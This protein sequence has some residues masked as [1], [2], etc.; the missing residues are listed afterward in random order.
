MTIFDLFDVF[1]LK[2]ITLSP[3]RCL[4]TLASTEAPSIAGAPKVKFPLSSKS[5]TLSKET[6]APSLMI[7]DE[8][9]LFGLLQF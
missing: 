7:N 1:F 9:I 6:F 8:Q 3:F 4:K 5:N 2:T